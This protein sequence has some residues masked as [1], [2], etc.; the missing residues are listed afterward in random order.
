MVV[1]AATNIKAVAFVGAAVA[2]AFT[3][4]LLDARSAHAADFTVNSTADPGGGS[5][6]ATECTLRE[7]IN[8]S[9]ASTTID[10]TIK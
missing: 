5:C 7:A 9:N 8:A 2:V 1:R 6:T 4:I 3:F 10:D